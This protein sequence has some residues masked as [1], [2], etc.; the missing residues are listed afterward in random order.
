MNVGENFAKLL[1]RPLGSRMS[2]NITMQ[3]SPGADLH[4]DEYIQ[5]L[6]V[7]RDPYKEVAADDGLGLVSNESSPALIVSSA[8]RALFFQVLS[9]R[10]W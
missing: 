2:R 5:K 7:Q 9:D 1:R 3:N 10:S 6:K 8:M 4:C